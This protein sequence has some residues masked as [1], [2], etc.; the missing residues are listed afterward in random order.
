MPRSRAFERRLHQGRGTRHDVVERTSEHAA[1]FKTGMA[2]DDFA[3]ACG[4][5]D[6]YDR[7]SRP[8][9]SADRGCLVTA[10]VETQLPR[11]FVGTRAAAGKI[12]NDVVGT[13]GAALRER[14]EVLDPDGSELIGPR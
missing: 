2:A 5:N 13:A 7:R 3:A 9:Q 6:R 10:A 12:E 8:D 4:I 1:V 14:R 11:P